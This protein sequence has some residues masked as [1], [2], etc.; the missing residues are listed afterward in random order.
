MWWGLGRKGI[1]TYVLEML[2]FRHLLPVYSE[3]RSWQLDILTRQKRDCRWRQKPE[4]HDCA[5]HAQSPGNRCSIKKRTQDRTQAHG[6][7][8]KSDREQKPVSER[9]TSRNDVEKVW[10]RM[11]FKKEVVNKTQWDEF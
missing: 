10:T 2:S 6:E 11:H 9:K 8:R 3:L 1:K 4:T 7:I 5:G